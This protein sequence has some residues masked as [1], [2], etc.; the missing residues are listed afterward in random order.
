VDVLKSIFIQRNMIKIVRIHKA[1]SSRTDRVIGSVYSIYGRII[2]KESTFSWE[3]GLNVLLIVPALTFCD[4]PCDWENWTWKF[5]DF[6]KLYRS[7]HLV[8]IQNT[9]FRTSECM[10]RSWVWGKTL[11][12]RRKPEKLIW[13]RVQIST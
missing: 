8:T 12:S 9:F 1:V 2:M 7:W 5:L 4:S 10:S 6:L 11:G 3:I 13:M